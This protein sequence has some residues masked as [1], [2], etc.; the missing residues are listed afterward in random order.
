MNTRYRMAPL[1][2]PLDVA[3]IRADF[4]IFHQQVNGK[5]LVFLDSAASSQKPL[6]APTE[7]TDL[8]ASAALL[9]L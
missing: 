5:R 2:V 6:D 8:F 4:P 9:Q 3:H 7:L 1:D